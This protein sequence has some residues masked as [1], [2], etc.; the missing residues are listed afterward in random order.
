MK[1]IAALRIGFIE[2]YKKVNGAQD[3]AYG[4]GE[5]CNG[6]KGDDLLGTSSHLFQEQECSND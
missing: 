4:T 1:N 5:I 2:M 3:K 6:Q